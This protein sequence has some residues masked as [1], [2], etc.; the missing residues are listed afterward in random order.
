MSESIVHLDNQV[1]DEYTNDHYTGA[2]YYIAL[3]S[4]LF[5]LLCNHSFIRN[6]NSGRL[7]KLMYKRR[8]ECL[9]SSDYYNNQTKI[10]HHDPKSVNQ[11]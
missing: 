8:E 9:V 4:M 5:I 3:E 6:E 11:V 7:T 10:I 2:V 1:S